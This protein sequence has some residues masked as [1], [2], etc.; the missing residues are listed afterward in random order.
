MARFDISLDTVTINKRLEDLSPRIFEYMDA[1]TDFGAQKG[2]EHMKRTAPWTDRTSAARNGL[3]TAPSSSRNHWE[4]LFS[5]VV[6]YGIWLEV[7][8][9][10][11]YAV[12][13]PSVKK[14]GDDLMAHIRDMLSELDR[15]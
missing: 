15:L 2:V 11:K 9:S 12:I 7:K 4:I 13:M 5:H 10:G 3:F 14:I 8:N 1:S 6:P